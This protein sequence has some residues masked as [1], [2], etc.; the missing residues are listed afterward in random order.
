MGTYHEDIALIHAQRD[1]E[2]RRPQPET[3][4]LDKLNRSTNPSHKVRL[5]VGDICNEFP[6]QVLDEIADSIHNA[7]ETGTEIDYVSIGRAVADF[8]THR[9]VS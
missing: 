3:S 2:R 4:P 8:V 6:P 5:L 9:I 7:H 1:Y